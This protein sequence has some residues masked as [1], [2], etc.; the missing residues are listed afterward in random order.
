M[1]KERRNFREVLEI[2]SKIRSLQVLIE[3]F[4]RKNSSVIFTFKDVC[5]GGSVLGLTLMIRLMPNYPWTA[6]LNGIIGMDLSLIF[7]ILYKKA[8][9]IPPKIKEVKEKLAVSGAA[10]RSGYERKEL[11]QRIWSIPNVAVT[12]GGF[13][14]FERTSTLDFID[15][16]INKV[17]AALALFP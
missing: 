16:V 8:F 15:F 3:L 10:L 5:L 7:C 2:Y 4:N 14:R 12:V 6:A 13:H 17:C 11:R 9:V 1:E